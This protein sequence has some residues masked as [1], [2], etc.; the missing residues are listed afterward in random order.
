[1]GVVE[2]GE[3]THHV[4]E[5]AWHVHHHVGHIHHGVV[6]EAVCIPVHGVEVGV[7]CISAESDGVDLVLIS[8][9]LLVIMLLLLGRIGVLVMRVFDGLLFALC[10]LDDCVWFDAR[11]LIHV[12]G[13]FGLGLSVG[14]LGDVSGGRRRRQ[15]SLSISLTS[16]SW[17]AEPV[18]P[19]PAAAS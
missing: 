8:V 11:C 3:L 16:S 17:S 4:G 6:V 9:W 7:G 12:F 14:E 15:W 2:E 18:A 1:M 10:R 13:V 19:G 5:S